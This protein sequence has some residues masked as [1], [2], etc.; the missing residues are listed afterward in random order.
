ML[1]S[2][3]GGFLLIAL[4]SAIIERFAFRSQE[5]TRRAEYTV[6]VALLAAAILAGFGAADEG[7]FVWTAGWAYLPGAILVFIWYRR[8]YM[9]AWDPN[10]SNP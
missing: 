6:G 1:G 2:I 7:S 3:V 4:L 9:N 10:E 8:R 5:P